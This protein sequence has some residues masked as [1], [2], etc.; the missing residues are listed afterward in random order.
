M[1]YGIVL[2]RVR[3]RFLINGEAAGRR[4]LLFEVFYFWKIQIKLK[5]AP[6]FGNRF[7]VLALKFD[8]LDIIS[9]SGN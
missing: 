3:V 4:A 9:Y 8:V 1:S 7:F 2:V 6:N 5:T